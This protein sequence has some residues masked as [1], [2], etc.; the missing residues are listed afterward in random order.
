MKRLN[1]TLAILCA[2]NC[3]FAQVTLLE[4][5]FS[6]TGV[7]NEGIVV[8]SYNPLSPY[9][10][11]NPNGG[12][13]K[14]IGGVSAGEGIGGKAQ[15]SAD[16]K[17]LSGTMYYDLDISTQWEKHTFSD[18][19][20]TFTDIAYVPNMI[21]QAFAVGRSDINNP[22]GI[23]L[24]T[25]DDGR[26]W[27]KSTM[28]EGGLEAIDFLTDNVV[29]IGGENATFAASLN[30]G[31]GWTAL[32]PRP[33]GCTDV[34]TTYKVIDFM[35]EAPYYGVVGAELI[36]GGYAV[37]QSPD[38][39]ETW[40]KATGV[41]GVPLCITHMDD[42]F[43]MGTQNG[44][45]QKSTDK[46]LTWEKIFQTGGFLQPITP[47][48]KIKFADT[49]TGIATTTMFIYRTTDGGENWTPVHIADDVPGNVDFYDILWTDATHAIVIG[50]K[51]YAYQSDDAG[52]TW[53]KLEIEPDGTSDL[54]AITISKQAVNICG[55]DGNMYRQSRI[56]S[57]IIAG[58]GRYDVEAETWTPLGNLNY[59]NQISDGSGYAISGDGKTVVGLSQISYPDQITIGNHAHA[60][61]WS[62]DGGLCDLGSL[63]NHI[64]RS[65]RA[66][67]VN[68]DGSVIVGWQDR[69]GPWHSA[70]WRKNE[71]GGYHPNEYIL[72]DPNESP[73]ENNYAWECT[74][75]S[76]DGKWIGG[77][78]IRLE[79]SGPLSVLSDDQKIRN[80]PWI[81]SESSGFKRLGMIDE[82]KDY[83]D[84][85]AHVTGINNDGSTVVGFI[86]VG[87]FMYGFIWTKEGGMQSMNEYAK[88]KLGFE[89]ESFHFA[90]VLAMSPDGHYITGW[91]LNNDTDIYAFQV[92]ILNATG[93]HTQGQADCIATVYPNPVSDVLHV[94]VP[95]EG[96][97]QIRLID[98]QGRIVINKK[99]VSTQN[100]L[101]VTDI[102]SGLYVLEVNA[103]GIHK[104]YK[105][106]VNH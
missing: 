54:R 35:K 83:P 32:D 26:S 42:V 81:W 59:Y 104:S 40:E 51:G 8:G 84:A 1:V 88:L 71:T 65:T 38:G 41:Q 105:I 75:V 99:T 36:D 22:K 11:W 50:A 57:T 55:V 28:T 33:S 17:F 52:A 94:D 23:V 58:M 44:C 20:Y 79:Q 97:T 6:P 101:S 77:R 31:T 5:A 2:V 47:I 102:E 14:E 21:S 106:Q 82:L 73:N 93:I 86:V 49:N 18:C 64:G 92:D 3:L 89:S 78:G 48:N 27:K 70:V 12:S 7:S 53:T 39:A 68:Y 103:K 15:F 80:Q 37:Y 43:Y 56:N 62:E 9:I 76:L 25:S 96:E 10:L 61:A 13:M 87:N 46:G 74:A 95:L 29:L 66:N 72:I 60:S 67:A 45:I 98:T 34:V 85:V 91:G 19:N 16:G 4:E 24:T 100:E 90:S 69:N 30:R 63:Y